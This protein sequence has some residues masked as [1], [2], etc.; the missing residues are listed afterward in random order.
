M[1]DEREK[2]DCEYD[3]EHSPNGYSPNSNTTDG[4]NKNKTSLKFKSFF[5][6]SSN[7]IPL[8]LSK[9]PCS[10]SLKPNNLYSNTFASLLSLTNQHY[11][12]PSTSRRQRERTT[13]D[14]HE[15]TPRLLQ[16]F[17]DT[18]H[19]TRYQIASICETLNN[20]PCRKGIFI[21]S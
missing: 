14:P 10:S 11:E 6:Y 12:S 1:S 2:I 8:N 20:L 17:T 16:I 21:N 9:K 13:F 18:K 19:P 4:Y 15:E 5:F 7:D 3:D